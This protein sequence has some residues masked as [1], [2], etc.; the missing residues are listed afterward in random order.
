MKYGRD[1]MYGSR[2][3][4]PPKPLNRISGILAS[5]Y[6]P[7]LTA[8]VARPAHSSHASDCLDV[9]LCPRYKYRKRRDAGLSCEAHC[10]RLDTISKGF[11]ASV[12]EALQHLCHQSSPFWR[13]RTPR[14]NFVRRV[15]SSL[16]MPATMLRLFIPL[17][18]SKTPC[19]LFVVQSS[20]ELQRTETAP[21]LDMF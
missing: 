5:A 4:G 18:Q 12:W 8:C 16:V 21:V 13:S 1:G 9:V 17:H 14:L 6:C 3:S 7:L 19:L 10:H 20:P 2:I 11:E 15:T